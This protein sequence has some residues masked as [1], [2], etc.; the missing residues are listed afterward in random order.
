MVSRQTLLR[1]RYRDLEA[2]RRKGREQQSLRDNLEG[3]FEFSAL[4]SSIS[5]LPEGS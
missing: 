5:A 4:V 3:R 2:S 1:E